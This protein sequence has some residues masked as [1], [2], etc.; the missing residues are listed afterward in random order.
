MKYLLLI[1]ALFSNSSWAE[2]HAL[3]SYHNNEYVTVHDANTQRSIASITKLFTAVT[4]LQSNADVD[5]Y[6][7]V[8]CANRGHIV[9]GTMMSRMDLMTAMIVS[10]DNCAAETLA[11]AHP[12]G[13][14]KFVQD[15]KTM[16]S[17]YKLDHTHLFDSTGLSV[18]NISTIN[19]LV[20]F[21]PVIY[22]NDFLRRISSLP[23]VDV[24]AYRRGKKMTIH[25]TNTN[26]AFYSHK[27]IVVSKTGYTKMAGRCVLMMVQ[28]VENFY[29][30][31]V[32]GQPNVKSRSNQVEKLLASVN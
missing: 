23:Q 22:Q 16:L 29:A 1:L 14:M 28:K 9:N 31:V 2:S 18:F 3:Y 30:V 11:N 4:I 21:A 24:Y 15:R 25:L 19:D 12:G 7:I 6:I 32:L 27:N 8:Q 13:Y 26:P 20:A 5:E 10:S 17:N